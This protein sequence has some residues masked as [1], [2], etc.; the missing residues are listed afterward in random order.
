ML[1]LQSASP[2]ASAGEIDA[3]EGQGVDLYTDFTTY[4]WGEHSQQLPTNNFYN[5]YPVVLSQASH[6]YGVDW[7]P[8]G[9]TWYLDGKDIGSVNAA[10]A[11]IDPDPMYLILDVWLGGWDQTDQATAPATMTVTDVQ[12]WQRAYATAS[13]LVFAVQPAVADAGQT[14]APVAVAIEDNDGNVV[15]DDSSNVVLSFIRGP[16]ALSGCTTVPAVN[17]VAVFSDLTLSAIG[18]YR[19]EARDSADGL[20]PITSTFEAVPDWI[21][22]ESV[23]TWDAVSSTLTLPFGDDA[24]ISG[25]PDPATSG[26][27][28]P[29]IVC[30]N[31]DVLAMDTPVATIG[32]LTLQPAAR[33]T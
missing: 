10:Q 30:G 11:P 9:V 19:L 2:D 23:G 5:D 26:N 12:V 18:N 17:G 24:W 16:G 15:A 25:D 1:P 4:H 21:D 22:R 28:P 7:E 20:L 32:N 14:M 3:Y 8:T 33:W 29:T 6:T 27:V 13:Q 31:G